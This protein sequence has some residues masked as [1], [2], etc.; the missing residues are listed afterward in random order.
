MLPSEVSR[1]GRLT[2]TAVTALVVGGLTATGLSLTDG[3]P[4]RP[5]RSATC[6]DA[7]G[8]RRDV[9]TD[10]APAVAAAGTD[11]REV[12]L[13]A[14]TER[15]VVRFLS[16]EPVP[17]DAGALGRDVSL[18]VQ[19]VVW[20]MDGEDIVYHLRAILRAD[21]WE[22]LRDD[23]REEPVVAATSPTIDGH[24]LRWEVGIA[25]LPRLP[26]EFGWVALSTY[27]DPPV[28]DV[29][30]DAA[31]DSIAPDVQLRFPQPG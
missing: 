19:W 21:G 5:A 20:V 15:L 7:A 23:L 18:P 28:Q 26:A 31:N 4:A 30:P 16:A 3:D 6:S 25:D 29:C 11:L 9:A 14:D 1:R 10:A 24:E 22:L 17:T 2:V 8:D 13:D 27:G 12:R